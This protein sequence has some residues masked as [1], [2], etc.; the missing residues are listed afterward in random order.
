[1]PPITWNPYA[2]HA[3]RISI[4][5]IGGEDEHVTQKTNAMEE[6]DE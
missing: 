4:E 6:K 5:G 3:M 1:M 2:I